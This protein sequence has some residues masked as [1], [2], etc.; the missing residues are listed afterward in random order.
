MN[1]YD[2]IPMISM[3]NINIIIIIIINLS[4]I[5]HW[6]DGDKF[7]TLCLQIYLIGILDIIYYPLVI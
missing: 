2:M 6:I 3:I 7:V 5:I 1:I 4:I